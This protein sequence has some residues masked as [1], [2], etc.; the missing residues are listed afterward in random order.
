MDTEHISVGTLISL[1][2]NRYK[3]P[4]DIFL[5]ARFYNE[6]ITVLNS[7]LKYYST[8][9]DAAI[10][11]AENTESD[12]YCVCEH[13]KTVTSVDI[14]L[15]RESN[16]NVFKKLVK[17]KP[18]DAVKILSN[19]FIYGSCKDKIGEE[20]LKKYEMVN[21]TDLK[22]AVGDKNAEIYYKTEEKSIGLFVDRIDEIE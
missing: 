4:D 16:P 20:E 22:A 8:E 18:F 14:D 7:L 3:I 10:S 5:R 12:T 2:E 19:D 6:L 9:Y 1:I 11:I 13:K 21:K 17:I 15:L